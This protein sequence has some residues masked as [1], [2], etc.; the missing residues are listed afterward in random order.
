M[1]PDP[2]PDPIPFFIGFMN[3]KNE[4]FFIIFFLATC[5]QAHHLQSK[6]FN[7]VLNFLLKCYI[8]DIISVRSTH[9]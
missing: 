6:K 8:A 4:F 7:F 5:P 2:I 9:L 1:D 3:A